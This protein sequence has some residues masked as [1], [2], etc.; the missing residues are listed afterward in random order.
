MKQVA[1]ARE[2]VGFDLG[3]RPQGGYTR[4]VILIM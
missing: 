1:V 4:A 3:Y 2:L